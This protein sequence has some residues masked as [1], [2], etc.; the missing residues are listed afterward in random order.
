MRDKYVKNIFLRLIA[1]SVGL[2]LSLGLAELTLRFTGFEPWHYSPKDLGEPILH[3][4]DPVLG[5]KNKPG[6]YSYPS[7]NGIGPNVE[8]TFLD[9]SSRVTSVNRTRENSGKSV[10]LVGCSFTEGWAV[11]DYETYSWKLQERFPAV[12]FYNYGTAGYGTYQSLLMLERVLPRIK[13]PA[14]VIYGFI[15]DHEFRNVA[16]VEWLRLMSAYSHRAHLYLPYVTV[17][18]S[19]NLIRH[20]PEKYT[21]FPFRESSALAAFAEEWYTRLKTHGRMEQRHEATEKLILEMHKNANSYGA[22][23]LVVLLGDSVAE[24]YFY[25]TFFNMNGIESIDCN[26]SLTPELTV[27]VEGH[28]NG[29]AHSMWAKCINSRLQDLLQ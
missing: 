13:S 23:F 14:V 9:D 6:H 20:E 29:Q 12:K 8:V 7:Y 3:E 5:W 1:V 16:P 11:S 25:Q 24:R 22:N 28:P 15:M 26:V 19:G 4:V 10:V 18:S 21:T 2:L 27:P 17:D